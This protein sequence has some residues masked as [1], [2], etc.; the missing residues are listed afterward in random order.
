MGRML[1]Q[2]FDILVGRN[3]PHEGDEAPVNFWP[4]NEATAEAAAARAGRS[5]FAPLLRKYV[6]DHR[7]RW[8]APGQRDVQRLSGELARTL[9]EF[10]L[11]RCS[12]GKDL[13]DCLRDPLGSHGGYFEDNYMPA[14]PASSTGDPRQDISRLEITVD[15]Q[16]DAEGNRRGSDNGH[17]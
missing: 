4:V 16:D 3:W 9:R 12:E 5:C 10:L 8:L 7:M 6:L 1:A 14:E 13:A 15:P 2:G 11:K 17:G